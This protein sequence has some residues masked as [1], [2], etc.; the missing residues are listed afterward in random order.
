MSNEYDSGVSSYNSWRFFVSNTEKDG[1]TFLVMID[2]IRL[3]KKK[4][5]KR[6]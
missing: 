4:P 2:P 6:I 1:T 3:A 5:W